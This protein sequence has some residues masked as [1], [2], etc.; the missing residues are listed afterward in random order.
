MAFLPLPGTPAQ[1]LPPPPAF[2]PPK[3]AAFGSYIIDCLHNYTYVWL[4][5]GDSF[6]YYPTRVEYGEVSGYRWSGAYWFYFGI[7]PRF[8]NAVSCPPIPTLY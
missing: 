6:W 2:I 1:T 5:N 3:P 4:W 7:D 8:I